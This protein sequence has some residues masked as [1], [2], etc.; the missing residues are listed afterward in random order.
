MDDLSLPN[1]SAYQSD[2]QDVT[3]VRLPHLDGLLSQAEATCM[4]QCSLPGLLFI[5]CCRLPPTMALLSR[6]QYYP[7]A[8]GSTPGNV[9][10]GP[11]PSLDV[12]VRKQFGRRPVWVFSVP[13]GCRNEDGDLP[14][15]AAGD[16]AVALA[17][18]VE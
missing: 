13:P 10:Q 3:L 8:C 2:E 12:C 1:F 6:L 18:A 17:P 7:T 9:G 14:N 11:L 15:T 4:K 5:T 16:L